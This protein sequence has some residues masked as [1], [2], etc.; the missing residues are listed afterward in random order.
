MRRITKVAVLGS[1]VMGSGIACHFANIGLQVLLL[2]IL[3]PNASE[4]RPNDTKG[5]NSVANTALTTA[6]KSKPAPL[7]DAAFASR[8]TTGNFED[9]FPKIKDY[10]WV[11]EV[12]IERLD[13]KQQIFDKVDQFRKKGTLVT[14]NTSGIPIHMMLEAMTSG[15]I[16]VAHTS[17][18]RLAICGCLKSF[19]QK[20]LGGT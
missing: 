17:S 4:L 8:I 5:R 9:D 12:V 6:I 20:K 2:D 11:I 15:S 7:Y 3:P 14:S 18:T 10:D 1:G 19:Q 13:I 16:F